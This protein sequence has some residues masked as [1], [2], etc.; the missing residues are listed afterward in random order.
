MLSKTQF[1]VIPFYLSLITFV[2][3]RK[4]KFA[5]FNGGM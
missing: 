3:V 5:K 2:F 4:S 1:D